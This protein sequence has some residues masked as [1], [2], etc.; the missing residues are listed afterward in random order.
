M[1]TKKFDRR[2][3]HRY[4]QQRQRQSFSVL[5]ARTYAVSCI[6]SVETFADYYDT[7][8]DITLAAN[9]SVKARD[10]RKE[11]QRELGFVVDDCLALGRQNCNRCL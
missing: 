4:I 9:M 3:G 8:S 11:D 5:C 1:H 2:E 10:Q 6:M 7:M